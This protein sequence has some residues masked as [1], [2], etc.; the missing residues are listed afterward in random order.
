MAETLRIGILH[1]STGTM[2][3]SEA[4]LRD[5]ILM[6]VDRVNARGGLLGR[7][8][9]PVVVDPG[10]DWI[11]YRDMAHSLIHEHRVAAI[12]G[13]WTS[14]SRKA[15]L[16]VVEEANALLFYP[17]QYEGEEQSPNVF[18]LGATP[19][20]QAMPAIEFLLSSEGGAYGRFF[21]L[22]TD[23]GYPRATHRVLRALLHAKGLD[24][25]QFP[26]HYVPFGHHDWQVE[27]EA[28]KAFRAQG[29]GA[30]I[31]TLNGD[32][33]LS[34]YRAV[35]A[36]GLNVDDLPIMALSVSETELQS[37]AP[38]DI[39]GQYA[40]WDYFMSYPSAANREF[41]E[42][43]RRFAGDHRPVYAP[44]VATMTGFRLWCKAVAAA[45]TTV[46][47]AVRQYMLGQSEPGLTDS[48][49]L[50]GVNHH[51]EMVAMVGR[52]NRERQFDIVWRAPR[53]I[54]GDP[55]A[56]ASIIADT[57][58]VSTQ[59]EI[60]EALPSPLIVIDEQ[61]DVK[62]Q[63]RSATEYFGPHIVDRP[64]VMLRNA[65]AR[66]Q[67][68][69]P[70]HSQTALP[71][72]AVPDAGGQ[73]RHLTVAVSRVVFSG[74]RA[75]LLCLSDIT[76]IRSIESQLRVLNAE[77]LRLATTD[78]LTGAHNR[79]HFTDAVNSQLHGLRRHRRPASIFILDL[80]HFKRL[81]DRHGHDVGDRALTE[82]AVTMRAALRGQ[83]IFA[84]IGGE[85]FAG[86]LP[87]TD[88][89]SAVHTVER[90]RRDIAGVRIAVGG[91]VAAFTCSIGVTE[92]DPEVDSFE[93]ALKRA[94]VGLYAAKV[95]GRD[96]VRRA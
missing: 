81:N 44:M 6:E 80:D 37:L 74:S 60:L 84:R 36:A 5:V 63:S 7:M 71:E 14:A 56:A 4:S 85:E 17:L 34:F 87:D 78:A 22:G 33:N 75:H 88:I 46:T 82:A 83:D 39:A 32:S 70:G 41:V 1:S 62:Y 48:V 10:S 35:R 13:C 21:F 58:A 20:Q 30:V 57:A 16:P 45:G 94:D 61:G 2:A 54:P 49:A 47:P 23:Y 72:I 67:E 15:V 69:A 29:R 66:S 42:E 64:L 43:W 11:R 19:N 12:F 38:D 77:L 25:T 73:V 95:E 93:I 40:C 27:I 3:L 51:V 68:N 24:V 96:R 86:Y 59:R 89:D 90:L 53:P 9:E 91:D 79:R 55:W 76:Y 26:E 92:I 31:S 28:L 50:M 52:A 18:Y 65:I 8:V